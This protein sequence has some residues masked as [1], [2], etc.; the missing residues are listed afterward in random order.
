MLPFSNTLQTYKDIRQSSLVTATQNSLHHAGVSLL[1]N[2]PCSPISTFLS[3]CF[4]VKAFEKSSPI[5]RHSNSV[6]KSDKKFLEDC[7]KVT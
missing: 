3:P 2:N 7:G 5:T 4:Y 1:S 6:H